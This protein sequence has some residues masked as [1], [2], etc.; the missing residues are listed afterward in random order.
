ML[1]CRRM[2][3]HWGGWK[4]GVRI[5]KCSMWFTLSCYDCRRNHMM[6]IKNVFTFYQKKSLLQPQKCKPIKLKFLS[7][8]QFEYA[9]KVPESWIKHGRQEKTTGNRENKSTK[10]IKVERKHAYGKEEVKKPKIRKWVAQE[11]W[12]K[13]LDIY[14]LLNTHQQVLWIPGTTK[15]T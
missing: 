3:R 2:L 9:A 10:I 13:F 7:W 4:L 5:K 6:G 12:V 1:I 14:K 8:R 11:I 15:T